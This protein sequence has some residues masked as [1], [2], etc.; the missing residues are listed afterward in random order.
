MYVEDIFIKFVKVTL[1]SNN[2]IVPIDDAEICY[3]FNQ[4]IIN[5]THL[6]ENQRLYV[7]SL[8][9]RYQGLTSKLG[10][11]YKK[12]LVMPRWKNPL[13]I[14]NKEKTVWIEET[15]NV[16]WICFKFPYE[17]KAPF[18]EEIETIYKGRSV[19]DYDLKVRK[20]KLYSINLHLLNE[21]IE[22]YGFTVQKS[23]ADCFA[24]YEEILADYENIVPYATKLDDNIVLI[25]CAKSTEEYWNTHKTGVYD[26]DLL[27]I[28]FLGIPYVIPTI[29]TR[30]EKIA[31][32]VSNSFWFPD[33][34]DFVNACYATSG[35][36]G[37]VL[38]RAGNT[39]EWLLTLFDTM[40]Q[41]ELD[42]SDIKVCINRGR[43]SNKELGNWLDDHKT[44][45]TNDSKILIFLHKPPKW[46]F[47]DK[48]K[49]DILG[50]N[51]IYPL[52]HK[53][54][55]SWLSGHPCVTYLSPIYPSA[56]KGQK[57]VKL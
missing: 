28:K 25:N 11:N 4:T 53:L 55:A 26:S 2:S 30:F 36:I 52:P 15:D 21:F 3:S 56:F 19:W 22:T 10:F 6:T 49:F 47:K 9:T 8:L 1:S 18:D 46:I 41:L 32:T 16:E 20:L 29:N 14:I 35:R 37:I 17:L 33:M 7:L 13:R 43:Q 38:D 44:N 27:L 5:D 31:S 45:G 57:I 51:A 42:L 24:R 39:R 50:T 34:L 54:T 48:I 40:K 23:Y 12:H